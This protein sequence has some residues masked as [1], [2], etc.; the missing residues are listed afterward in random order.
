MLA[1]TARQRNYIFQINLNEDKFQQNKFLFGKSLNIAS[2]WLYR[3]IWHSLGLLHSVFG[4]QQ[5]QFDEQFI[6]K[7]SFQTIHFKQTRKKAPNCNS[8]D[9][10][11][12]FSSSSFH[13]IVIFTN[14]LFY[15]HF[16]FKT[17]LYRFNTYLIWIVSLMFWTF[18][19]YVLAYIQCVYVFVRKQNSNSNGYDE[20]QLVANY[21]LLRIKEAFTTTYL[22]FKYVY[23]CGQINSG[24]IPFKRIKLTYSSRRF[25]CFSF[26]SW[27]LRWYGLFGR[28]RERER[29]KN[30]V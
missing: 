19:C 29:D 16:Q 1:T 17:K 14:I 12:I 8:W 28:E 20:M 7:S 9:F 18:I 5:Q 4:Q 13:F 23:V 26:L 22:L 6:L 3:L 11:G 21:N 10:H 15:T 2:A 25:D 24:I 30:S 27:S